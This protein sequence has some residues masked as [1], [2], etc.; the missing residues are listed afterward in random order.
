MN[1]YCFYK[2]A[3]LIGEL[4]LILLVFFPLVAT[5]TDGP[6]FGNLSS[7]FETRT[8]RI[9]TPWPKGTPPE[10]VQYEVGKDSQASQRPGFVLVPEEVLTMERSGVEYSEALRAAKA[11]LERDFLALRVARIYRQKEDIKRPSYLVM[12]NLRQVAALASVSYPLA[13]VDLAQFFRDGRYG[14]SKNVPFFEY[15]ISSIPLSNSLILQQ[16]IESFDRKTVSFVVQQAYRR[17]PRVFTVDRISKELAV[18]EH[19]SIVHRLLEYR[20]PFDFVT[21]NFKKPGIGLRYTWA[22]FGEPRTPLLSSPSAAKRIVET[23][24]KKD[25]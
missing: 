18:N 24:S 20:S 15:L 16:A 5:A 1:H 23:E 17:Y 21:R 8:P 25:R 3:R 2:I 11:N 14:L 9:Q 7:F 13:M 22:A 4:A 19:I 10:L 6:I 12:Q